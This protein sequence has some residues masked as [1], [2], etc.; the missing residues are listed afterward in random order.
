MQSA[1]IIRRWMII[2]FAIFF[3][4]EL[5]SITGFRNTRPQRRSKVAEFKCL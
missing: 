5:I 3:N 1:A 2:Q 4:V